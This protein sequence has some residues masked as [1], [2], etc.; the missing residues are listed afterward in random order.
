MKLVSALMTLFIDN[1]M[2]C[3]KRCAAAQCEAKWPTDSAPRRIN[4]QHSRDDGTKG[5]LVRE[6]VKGH[7]AQML[8]GQGQSARDGVC[9]P[10]LYGIL[11]SEHRGR[12]SRTSAAGS[13]WVIRSVRARQ[14]ITDQFV[15]P[16]QGIVAGQVIHLFPDEP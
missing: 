4:R 1:I 3:L 13:L 14:T 6:G 15:R 5:D 8:R 12:K 9:S 10:T 16:P 2:Y 7:S 11:S